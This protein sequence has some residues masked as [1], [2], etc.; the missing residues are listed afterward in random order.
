MFR[1]FSVSKQHFFQLQN[2]TG[3]RKTTMRKTFIF[4]IALYSCSEKTL[5]KSVSASKTSKPLD[6]L[7]IQKEPTTKFSFR[8][9]VVTIFFTNKSLTVNPADIIRLKKLADICNSDSL[10]FLKVVGFTDTT[11]NEKANDILSEKRAN[12]I[13]NLLD[14]NN[15]I[16]KEI[17]YVA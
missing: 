4:I 5:D 10:D 3:K 1:K 11:G 6:S 7:A 12:K 15:R 2:V 13:Y 16:N 17:V 9:T 14:H 8:D